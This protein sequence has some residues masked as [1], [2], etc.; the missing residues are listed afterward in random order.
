LELNKKSM[1]FKQ[2]NLLSRRNFV[3]STTLAT[4]GILSATIPVA[5]MANVN[6]DKKLK[7]ALVGCGGRGTGAIVQAL[8]AD[9]NT[10]LVA[11]ADA[12][13]DRVEKSLKAI[14][15]HFDGV[16]KIKVKPKNLFSGFD[17]YKKAIDM[18]DVV[19]LTTPPGFR[20]YH[21][22]YAIQNGKHVFMEKPVATDPVGVRKG[23][24]CSQNGKRKK[25]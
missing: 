5:A 16:K 8:Q 1:K 17:A 10:E 22:E 18:A 9:E 4:T 2:N 3:K 19:I 15:E 24:G 21:F 25:A 14:Q 11:M 20:P 23:F 6:G 12:F 13:Q 7:L